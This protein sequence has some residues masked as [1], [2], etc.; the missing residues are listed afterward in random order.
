[1]AEASL[2]LVLGLIVVLSATD[3][4]PVPVALPGIFLLPARVN[5]A[6]STFDHF[7]FDTGSPF[8]WMYHYKLVRNVLGK[9]DGGYAI[10]MLRTHIVPPEGGMEIKY[11]DESVFEAA[12]WTQKEF[13]IGNHKWKEPFG[14]IK[15]AEQNSAIPDMTGLIGASR[16]SAFVK[17]HPVFGFSPLSLGSMSMHLS[18]QEPSVVCK[19]GEF[20]K[21]D[22]SK[23]SRHSGHWAVD[24]EVRYSRVQ[25]T[26]GVIFDTGSSVLVLN[27]PM[28]NEYQKQL[29]R[30]NI[31]VRYDEGSLSGVVH[32]RYVDRLPTWEIRKGGKIIP[33]TPYMYVRRRSASHCRVL[34][35]GVDS[36][37]SMIIGT[38]LLR[39][40]VSEFDSENGRVSMC[41]PIKSFVDDYANAFVDLSSEEVGES[42]SCHVNG[43]LSI[44]WSFTYLVILVSVLVSA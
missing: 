39:W 26:T 19:D 5:G 38:P 20:T 30:L 41:V 23:G 27:M 37:H 25:F 3:P 34:V 13:Q 12:L 31:P 11:V 22:L 18:R 7:L 2:L 24:V 42:R 9:D 17:S 28:F 32:C 36:T 33:I 40:I 6:E 1:M 16:T 15:R 29:H 14:I 43:G 4:I 44:F 10:T 21:F 8:T 35:G